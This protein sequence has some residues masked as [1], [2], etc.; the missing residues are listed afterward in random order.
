S[1]NGHIDVV[2]LLLPTLGVEANNRD[3]HGRTALFFAARFGYDNV[4]KTLLADGRIDTDIK[5]WYHSTSLFT[6][7]RNGHFAVVEVLLATGRMALGA[8]D[9]FGRSLFWWARRSGGLRVLELLVQHAGKTGIQI[10]DDP[11]PVNAIPILFDDKSA[12]CDA[13]T[14]SI[15]EGCGYRCDN[16]IYRVQD[17]I[18]DTKALLDLARAAQVLNVGGFTL[19]FRIKVSSGFR[20]W[21]EAPDATI[22]FNKAGKKM[23]PGTGLWLVKVD[24]VAVHRTC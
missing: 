20:D 12:W 3:N 11:A 2:K 18:D 21:L 16:D 4:V 22:G 7:V 10:P 9:G 19:N 24:Y 14:L 8:E 5:D 15:K 23:H 13:C 17:D 1:G 6:A